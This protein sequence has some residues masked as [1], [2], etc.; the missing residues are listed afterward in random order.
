M[1]HV[2]RFSRRKFLVGGAAVAGGA[3]V[4]KAGFA[5][6]TV[7][8]QDATPAADAPKGGIIRMAYNTPATLN[9]LFSTAG[10]DQGV[11][12][13]I[14]GALVRMTWRTGPELDL[15][16]AVDVAPDATQYTFTLHDGLMFNDGVPLTSEDVVYTFHTALDPRTGSFW[17]SRFLNL[18]EADTYDGETITEIAGIAAPDEKT[19]VHNLALPDATWLITLG[20]FAGFCIVPRHVFGE[21]APQDLQSSAVSLSPGPGA[22]AFTFGEY[23]PDQFVS[24]MRNDNY[25]PPKAN[26]DQLLLN[27]L[28]QTVTAMSQLQ[29]GEIDILSVTVPDMELV[30]N[31]PNLTLTA[32][33]SVMCQFITPNMSRP[34]FDDKRVRQALMYGL[35]RE[36][37]A[38]E[39]FGGYADVINSPFFGWEWTEED[40]ADLNPY[41]YDPDMA[42]QLLDEADWASG[43]FAP[44]MHYI[45]GDPFGES[46][47]NIVQ[48]QY[49]DIGINIELVQVD[50]TEYTNRVISGATDGNTGD[51]DILIGSGGVMGSD[52]NVTA[53]YFD[54]A[55]MTP[56]GANYSHFSN[57]RVDEL[58]IAGRGTTDVEERK[59]IYKEIAQILNDEVVWVYLFRLYAIYGISNRVQNFVPPGHPGRLISSAHEWYVQ[60]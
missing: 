49:A 54:T 6:G 8:A 45:P 9:P 57:A 59:T 41:N 25:D 40:L 18:Q 31:N 52:P 51:F 46:L 28:P 38:T 5:S 55:S 56:F 23:Q 4:A 42:R 60:Q 29:S 50:T 32:E 20:D 7:H 10:V 48:Q 36:T 44:Q 35:D 14:Y 12:R 21:I 43:N 19:V 53:R 39:L 11:E 34:V 26:I 16:S 24:I 22:G 17:R 1:H 3:L 13:Q 15:A 47:I 33:P 2:H 27:I 58:Y 30:T 37:I